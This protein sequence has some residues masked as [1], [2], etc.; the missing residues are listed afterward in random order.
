MAVTF[1]QSHRETVESPQIHSHCEIGRRHL[2]RQP[3]TLKLI[4]PFER[5]DTGRDSDV[6]DYARSQ[7]EPGKKVEQRSIDGIEPVRLRGFARSTGRNDALK[8]ASFALLEIGIVKQRV[9][10]R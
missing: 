8:E 9:V 1:R 2:N 3:L 7:V 4:Q 10:R 5:R 6:A